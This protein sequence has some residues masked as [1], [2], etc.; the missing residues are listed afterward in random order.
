MNTLNELEKQFEYLKLG[1]LTPKKFKD[2]KSK[3]NI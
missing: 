3:K 2:I 1:T